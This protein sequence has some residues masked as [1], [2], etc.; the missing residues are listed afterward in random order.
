MRIAV[1]IASALLAVGTAGAQAGAPRNDTPSPAAV[2]EALGLPQLAQAAR[3]I[4]LAQ[5]NNRTCRDTQNPSSGT[6][7]PVCCTQGTRSGCV[8]TEARCTALGGFVE[9]SGHDGCNV[10]LE[11]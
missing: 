4:Q 6:P 11:R 2:L 9:P 1:L 10:P 8:A 7:L 3:P 5:S